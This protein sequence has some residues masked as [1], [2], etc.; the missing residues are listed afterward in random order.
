MLADADRL[1]S[2]QRTALNRADESLV[3]SSISIWEAAMLAGR[4]RIV[5]D[6]PAESWLDELLAVRGLEVMPITPAIA[7]ESVSLPGELHKD[8][9]D[10]LIVATARKLNCPLVTC[11]Q[12]IEAYEHVRVSPR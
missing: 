1:S 3:I 6:A 10:R 9:A 2:V 7:V 8:P 4:G 12:K 11:D 5:I